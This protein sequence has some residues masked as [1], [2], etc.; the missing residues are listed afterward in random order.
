MIIIS[1]DFAVEKYHN[2]I[3]PSFRK[4]ISQ[5][6]KKFITELYKGICCSLIS[7]VVLAGFAVF[8]VGLVLINQKNPAAV[9]IIIV[10]SIN[11]KHL[12]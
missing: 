4:R 10:E 5:K 7:L 6:K 11:N 2:Q 3:L 12:N 9:T 1:K 8:I